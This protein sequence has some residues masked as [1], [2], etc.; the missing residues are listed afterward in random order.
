MIQEDTIV[1]QVTCPGKSAVGIIRVSGTEA[2]QVAI[3]ILGKIPRSRYATYSKFLDINRKLLDQ[4]ISLWFPAPHSFTGEDVLE[5]QGHGSP[6][7]MDLLI[8]SILSI[9]NVRIAR[10]GEFCQRAFLNDKIDLIQAEAIDDLINSETE[11]ISRGALNTLQGN[12]SSYIKELIDKIIKLRI[13]IE[14]RI[15]FPEENINFGINDTISIKLDK[16]YNQFL[17]IRNSIVEGSVIRERKKVVIVGPPNAGKSSLLNVLS[18]HNRAIVTNIPGT[19]RDIIHEDIYLN[20]VLYQIIDT[21]GLRDTDDEIEKIGI[22]K[23]WNAIKSVDHVLFIIDK[24]TSVLDQKRMATN[25]QKSIPSNI[26]VTFV[27]NK[28]DLVKENSRIK[29]NGNLV[30]INISTLTGEGIDVL[31]KHLTKKETNKNQESVFVARR[32]HLYQIDLSFRE[33]LKS[34]KKWSELKNI[35]FLADSLSFI[36]KLLGEITGE[37]TSN[38]LLNSI[39]STFCIGK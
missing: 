30:F 15:D 34:Y 29:K 17:K 33:F 27:L 9:K 7:V 37:F 35:E 14:S 24:T 25:F 38:D 21:A 10:P 20:G 5:L 31:K 23:T 16:I 39:F 18:C 36:N 28:N 19:T 6:L 22:Q 12:F 8:K 1:A 13:D 32:R 3:K 11:L 4:G 26:E 2:N